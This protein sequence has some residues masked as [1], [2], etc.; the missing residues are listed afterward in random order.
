[1]APVV[2]FT[3]VTPADGAAQ[4]HFLAT[5]FGVPLDGSPASRPIWLSP[6][7]M[8][9][10]Y[11]VPHPWWSRDDGRRAYWLRADGQ[12]A[13]H[14][15]AAPLRLSAAPGATPHETLQV[16]DWAAGGLLPGG[17]LLI[18]RKFLEMTRSTLLAIGGSADTRKLIP[19]V[20]WF[21]PRP[22]LLHYARPLRAWPYVRAN[23]GYGNWRA[24]ARAAR[25]GHWHATAPRPG[26]GVWQARAARPGEP[27]HTPLAAAA[28]D[29]LP[30]YRDRAW[31]D[32]LAACPAVTATLAILE[33][34]GSPAGHALLA[35]NP[36]GSV[37]AA[38]F[39]LWTPHPE[40]EAAAAFAAVIGY[41]AALP[42]AV[43]IQAGST[44]EAMHR[45][46]ASHGLRV[47]RTSPVHLADPRKLLPPG[48][49]V[50][51]TLSAGDAF[52]LYDRAQPF[53]C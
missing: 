11:F 4:W 50:E 29:Y 14:G 49:P 38:D 18:Y 52:Y 13:A 34:A 6:D 26:A 23:G 48:L 17:G 41:A 42:G 21:Q 46:F 44:L 28:A 16:I 10:K 15:C 53:Q 45:V 37:A 2:D 5:T 36:A 40:A 24:W 27:V 19:Q 9:W 22:P 33:R 8:E 51:V 3:A 12:P 32:Y 31:L 47:R 7:V 20:K 39:A 25:N 43:E 30:L 35:M 1:M